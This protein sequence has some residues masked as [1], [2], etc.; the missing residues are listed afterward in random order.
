MS[1]GEDRDPFVEAEKRGCV[2]VEP[3]ANELF[4]DIDDEASLAVFYKQIEIFS[5]G[6]PRPIPYRMT[7]SPSGEPHHFHIVV[8]W[9]EDVGDEYH[10]L[11]LQAILGSDRTR[12]ALCWLRHEN[13]DSPVTVFFEKAEEPQ[14]TTPAPAPADAQDEDILF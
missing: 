13:G 7:P 2:V 14:A 12:E 1:D 9:P 11:G 5:R 4:V 3:E 6:R 10:R 8:T